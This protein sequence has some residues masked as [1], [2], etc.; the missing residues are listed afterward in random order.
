[1]LANEVPCLGVGDDVRVFMSLMERAIQ[2]RADIDVD[3]A[4][5]G[6]PSTHLYYYRVPVSE[7]D[8]IEYGLHPGEI[9]D[10][11]RS[12]FPKPDIDWKPRNPLTGLSPDVV[13]GS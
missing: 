1:V 8:D 9:E 7:A 2:V 6:E 13:W 11:P 4:K 10:G 12:S 3:F 5:R